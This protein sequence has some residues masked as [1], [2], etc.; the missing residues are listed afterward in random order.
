MSLFQ[1]TSTVKLKSLKQRL[2]RD[3]MLVSKTTKEYDLPFAGG[4]VGDRVVV[5]ARVVVSRVVDAGVLGI[6]VVEACAVGVV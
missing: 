4:V 3:K 2:D 6:G 5:L 1:L